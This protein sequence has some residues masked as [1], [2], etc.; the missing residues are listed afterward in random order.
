MLTS[1]IHSCAYY[2][3]ACAFTM[4]PFS[5]IAACVRSTI[6]LVAMTG[7]HIIQAPA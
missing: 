7:R 2:P 5:C 1:L 6:R 3:P 4:L